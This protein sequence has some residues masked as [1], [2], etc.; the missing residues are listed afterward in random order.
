MTIPNM[1]FHTMIT[2]L[3]QEMVFLVL[4]P[5]NAVNCKSENGIT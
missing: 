5:V 2:I 1:P 3:N 4:Y